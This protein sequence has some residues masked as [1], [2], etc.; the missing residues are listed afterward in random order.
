[1]ASSEIELT[2]D[3]ELRYVVAVDVTCNY[4]SYW[5]QWLSYPTLLH[6][7][8][9]QLPTTRVR[10]NGSTVT[11]PSPENVPNIS[12]KFLWSFSPH[13]ELDI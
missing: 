12:V 8:L 3:F 13:A 11:V 10:G 5:C 6:S 2:D 7:Q 1:M 9:M 4:E